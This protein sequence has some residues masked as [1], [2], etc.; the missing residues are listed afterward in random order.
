MFVRWQPGQVT[1][2][3]AKIVV[4]APQPVFPHLTV[5]LCLLTT[6]VV[7]TRVSLLMM[8]WAVATGI[9]NATNVAIL[10]N[11]CGN[12]ILRL[13]QGGV[14]RLGRHLTTMWLV[15]KRSATP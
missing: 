10:V 13:R 1:G 3:G 12:F 14:A 7:D 6:N 8:V 11:T 9:D 2:I 4:F 5:A 15:S